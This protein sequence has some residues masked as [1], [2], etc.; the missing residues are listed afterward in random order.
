[1]PASLA[2]LVVVI[3]F[4]ASRPPPCQQRN[5]GGD[6]TAA[7]LYVANWRFIVSGQS[8]ADLFAAPSPVLHFWALA[9]EEQFYLV[10]PAAG[11]RAAGPAASGTGGSSVGP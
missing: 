4:G 5:L 11:L 7:L 3:A 9:I 10:L 6:V 8:Y 1:M 2:A